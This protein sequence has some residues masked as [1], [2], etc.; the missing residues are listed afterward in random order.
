LIFVAIESH[1]FGLSP[2]HAAEVEFEPKSAPAK[3]EWRHFHK[4]SDAQLTKL[5]S[6]QTGRGNK[7]LA[8]WSWQWRMGWLQRCG[9]Q[10]MGTI[11]QSILLTGLKDEAM[12]VRAEAATRIGERFAGKSNPALIDALAAAYRDKRNTRNGSPLF[13]CD[14]I[15]EALRKIGGKRASKVAAR[16]AK[17]YPETSVYWSK[18][19]RR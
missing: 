7:S 4:M 12:V 2:C 9:A 18:I 19:S 15:L 14:R 3:A 6:Y 5:W 13:V 17:T 8:D 10:T 11:C 16:L 1:P